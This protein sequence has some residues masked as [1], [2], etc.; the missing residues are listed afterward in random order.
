MVATQIILMLWWFS[1]K[2][3]IKM[4]NQKDLVKIVGSELTCPKLHFGQIGHGGKK[5]HMGVL[6]V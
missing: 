4:T 3:P 5:N 6:F 2:N 1:K